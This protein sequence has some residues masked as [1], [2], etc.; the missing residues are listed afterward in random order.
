MSGVQTCALPILVHSAVEFCDGAIIAQLGGADMA[1]PI[2][3]ALTY[4]LR[5][6]C[7]SKKISMTAIA[8]LTFEKPDESTFVCLDVARK[9]V[10][11]GGLYCCAVNA[12]NEV[13][14]ARF[15]AGEI[16]FFQIGELVQKEL[17]LDCAAE[18]YTIDD[19][20]EMDKIARKF[21]S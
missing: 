5:S 3:Y 16:G 4:P 14:V 1:V 9:A 7:E 13:A 10:A 18:K 20:Y 11:M 15:L 17:K 8:Q 21:I 2:Q 6:A 19:V 12:I